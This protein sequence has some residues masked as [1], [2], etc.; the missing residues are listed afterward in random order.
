MSVALAQEVDIHVV[1]EFDASAERVYTAFVAPDAIA[2]WFGPVGWGVDRS[3]VVVEPR[4]YGRYRLTLRRDDEPTHTF[5]IRCRV[6]EL[7]P[8]RLVMLE[9]RTSASQMQLQVDITPL[10]AHRCRIDLRQGPYS[11]DSEAM[12]AIG[13]ESAFAKLRAALRHDTVL[14]A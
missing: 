7:I 9:E 4:P 5:E 11:V 10:D 3:S 12:A 13:W 6:L 8:G 14:A 1:G 2:S